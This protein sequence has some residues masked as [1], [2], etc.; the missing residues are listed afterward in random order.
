MI[1]SQDHVF[2]ISKLG[3]TVKQFNKSSLINN[4]NLI[5]SPFY[6]LRE[7]S[8]VPNRFSAGLLIQLYTVSLIREFLGP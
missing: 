3:K 1:T 5:F 4:Q 8:Q 7:G 2:E 6:I